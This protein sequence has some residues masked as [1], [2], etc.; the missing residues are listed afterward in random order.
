M[1]LGPW[2]S[3][4]IGKQ[5]EHDQIMVTVVHKTKWVD[6]SRSWGRCFVQSNLPYG[7]GPGDG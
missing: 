4:P 7:G 3:G 5:P 2:G 1:C 6:T